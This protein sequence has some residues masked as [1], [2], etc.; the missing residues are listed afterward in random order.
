MILRAKRGFTIIELLV[1]IAIIGILAAIIYAGFG[2]SRALA[3]NKSFMS[4]LKQTQLSLE[5]YKAQY[6]RYPS[7]S[8]FSTAN[9]ATSLVPNFL[10]KLPVVGNSANSSCT[11]TYT[12]DTNGT[13][14][15]YTAFRCYYAT[16]ATQG[17]TT[18]NEFA[19]CPSSCGTTCAGATLDTTSVNFYETLAIYSLG[20]QCF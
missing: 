19:R 7:T 16:A 15:K 17:I 1:V 5:L 4:D 6:N 2:D 3:R 18:T 14:Y 20:G 11:L 12:T 13:Y 10:P 9:G 8:D